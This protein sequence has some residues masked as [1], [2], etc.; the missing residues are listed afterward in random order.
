MIKYIKELQRNSVEKNI[1]LK[2][3]VPYICF[4]KSTLSW[5][6][7]FFEKTSNFSMIK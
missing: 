2:N 1:F 5:Y 6:I 4:L 7:V 3:F